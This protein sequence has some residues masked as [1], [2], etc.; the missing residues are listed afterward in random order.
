MTDGI[1]DID[2]LITSKVL[3]L[4]ANIYFE[5]ALYTRKFSCSQSTKENVRKRKVD[6]IFIDMY[7]NISRLHNK[8]LM[9]L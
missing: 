8:K 9:L 5:P 2:S 1:V 6:V 7:K 3:V 4:C